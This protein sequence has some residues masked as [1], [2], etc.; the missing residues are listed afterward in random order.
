MLLGLQNLLI[1]LIYLF[2]WIVV[3]GLLLWLI[4]KFYWKKKH[5]GNKDHHFKKFRN[6]EMSD[7]EFKNQNLPEL[8]NHQDDQN[9]QKDSDQSDSSAREE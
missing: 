5:I 1:F 8:K 6:K 9:K 2:P 3:I 7:Q 4:R